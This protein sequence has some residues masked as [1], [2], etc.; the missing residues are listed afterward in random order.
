MRSS[1]EECDRCNS[2]IVE[3]RFNE[4]EL[5]QVV[6]MS[7]SGEF[8][9]KEVKLCSMCWDELWEWSSDEGEPDRSDVADPVPLDELAENVD[10]H[11]SDLVGILDDLED[12]KP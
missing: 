11:I 1:I 12:A 7:G 3:R 5:L 8:D 10:R 2:K 4:S 6:R 9:M